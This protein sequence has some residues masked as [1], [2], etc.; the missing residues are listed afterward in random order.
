[1]SVCQSNDIAAGA[2]IGGIR[3][4]GGYADTC[5]ENRRQTTPPPPYAVLKKFLACCG[6]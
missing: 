5:D 4:S 6:V 3:T 1:M 2:Y